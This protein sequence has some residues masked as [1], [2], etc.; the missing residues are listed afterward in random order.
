MC[1]DGVLLVQTGISPA[2]LVTQNQLHH[3]MVEVLVK[4]DDPFLQCDRL[5]N[6]SNHSGGHPISANHHFIAGFHQTQTKLQG[7]H[8]FVGMMIAEQNGKKC[9]WCSGAILHTLICHSV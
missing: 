7:K 4:N 6:F 5:D 2:S 9:V 1:H 8:P 3:F